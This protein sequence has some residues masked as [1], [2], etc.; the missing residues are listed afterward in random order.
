MF[1]EEKDGVYNSFCILSKFAILFQVIVSSASLFLYLFHVK[2]DSTLRV[3]KE[4]EFQLTF[5]QN[6]LHDMH[7]WDLIECSHYQKPI[8]CHNAIL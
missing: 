2:G 1:F 5:L 3:P 4:N 6:I 7:S 8:T